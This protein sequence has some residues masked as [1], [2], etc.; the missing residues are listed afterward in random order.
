MKSDAV[1]ADGNL[2]GRRGSRASS[3]MREGEVP[4][5]LVVR[6][7]MVGLEMKLNQLMLTRN[8]KERRTVQPCVRVIL[9]AS[10]LK[11]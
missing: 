10:D 4:L 8:K 7:V 2:M 5:E 1:C 11:I 3:G 9:Q 6:W